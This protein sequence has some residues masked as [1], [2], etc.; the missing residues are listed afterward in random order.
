MIIVRF[1]VSL[2]PLCLGLSLGLG[3][4][5]A[6]EVGGSGSFPMVTLPREASAGGIPM[7]LGRQLPAVAKWY[8]KSEMEFRTWCGREPSLRADRRGRLYYACPGLP[9]LGAAATASGA[10]VSSISTSD[11]VFQRHSKPGATRVVYLDFDGHTTSGT[12]WKSGATFVTPPYDTDGN[13]TFFSATEL[14][15]IQDIW[16]RVA[17]DYS[18]FDVDVTTQDPGLE[19]L[20]KTNSTDTAYGIRVCIGGSS[21]DWYGASAGGVAY[22]GSFSWSSDTPCY[23][24]EAQLGNGHPKYVAEAASHEAGHTVSLRHDGRTDDPA[25]TTVNEAKEYYEGHGN[26]API[27]GVGY[28]RDVVQ[29]SRGEYAFANNT[30]DDLTLMRNHMPLR[31]DDSGDGITTA[32]WL[33]GSSFNASGIISQRTDADLFGF[34]TGAGTISLTAAPATIAPNLDITLSLYNGVGNLISSANPSALGASLSLSVPAGTYYAAI[35]G[36]GLGT[37]STGYSDYGSLGQFTLTGSVVPTGNQPPIVIVSNSAPVSGIAPLTVAFSSAGTYDPD[38]AVA[39]YDWDFGDGTAGATAANPSHTYTAPGT[40]FASLVVTDTGGLSSSAMLTITVT[41]DNR[42]FVSSV[43]MSAS[44]N[45]GGT[46]ARAAVTIRGVDGLVKSGAT[47]TGTWSGIISGSASATTG[48]TGVATISSPRSKNS[49]TFTFTVTNVTASGS[50]YA[51]SLN[52][53]TSGSITR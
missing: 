41:G 40:Y 34:T 48:S 27:M 12:N 35:D 10:T 16:H 1:H 14:A 31:A 23:V 20:R 7:A 43:T 2:A 11:P 28:Y 4:P 53:A 45:K 39:A 9:M 42:I 47:V 51:P 38:G 37:A 30:E 5:V 13:L 24:F 29:F 17:E 26:W 25:T 50:T 6:A 44:S 18:A 22:L 15:N 19:S 32:A 3:L 33:A 46:T 8:G 36:S 21:S 49:G 52:T